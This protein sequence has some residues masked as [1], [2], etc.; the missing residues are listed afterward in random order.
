MVKD[1]VYYSFKD[2]GRLDAQ[3]LKDLHD[4]GASEMKDDVFTIIIQDN[5]QLEDK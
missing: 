1:N 3:W 5:A 2:E 4:V